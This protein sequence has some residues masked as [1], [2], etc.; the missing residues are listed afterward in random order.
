MKTSGWQWIAL[1]IGLLAVGAGVKLAGTGNADALRRIVLERCVPHQKYEGTPA[2]CLRV[3]LSDGYVL[4]KDKRGALQYLLMPTM[5]INGV[6]SPLLLAASAPNYFWQ[7]WQSR[8]VMGIKRGAPIP[9]AAIA[10]TLNSRFGR[11][12]NHLHIHIS[13][14]RRDTRAV[15]DR[16]AESI[17]T[18]WRPFPERLDGIH[19]LARRVTSHE[20]AQRGPFISLANEVPDARS[21]MGRYGIALAQLSGGDFIL[22]ATERNLLTFNRGSAETLQDHDCLIL[23]EP[24]FNYRR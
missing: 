22:L 7:A 1:L 5:R 21:H 8:N 6:E 20:L 9:D 11:T 12:Q 2:P 23:D 16:Y 18:L 19:Y 14:L 4:F 3:D 10:L 13:C 15:I 17:N 24:R